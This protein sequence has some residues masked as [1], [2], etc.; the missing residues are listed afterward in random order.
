M[1]TCDTTSDPSLSEDQ[2]ISINDGPDPAWWMSPDISLNSTTTP[3]QAISGSANDVRVRTRRARDCNLLEGTTNIIVE[4][5]VCDPTLNPTPTTGSTQI[6]TKL[7]PVGSFPGGSSQWVS[8]SWTPNPADPVQQIGHKCLIA[9]AYPE[10]LLPDSACFHVQKDSH[11]AQR[12]ISI[13]AASRGE[14]GEKRL[15]FQIKTNNTDLERSEAATLRVVADLNPS[16]KVLNILTPSLEKFPGYRHIVR[17]AP[18]GF[19][20]ELPD[21]PD[22]KVRDNTR[23]GCLGTILAFFGLLKGM[24][25]QP[26]YE[27][28]IELKP[29]QATEFTLRADL[30]SST[31]G[32]AQIFH[33]MHVNLQQQV[34]GGVTVIA[35]VV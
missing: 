19:K 15:R 2:C 30:S 32:D 16:Q 9:R 5:W 12:N 24:D 22:A 31:A 1:S 21:F 18:T 20:L 28:D 25:V 35:V 29:G 6:F 8:D 26:K 17:S 13:V 11:V 7:I 10:L 4:L 23:L 27:A 3:D 33:V 14:G 34:I